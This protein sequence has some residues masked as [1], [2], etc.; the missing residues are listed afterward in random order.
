[1]RGRGVDHPRIGVVD[2]RDGF[3][4]GVVRQAEDRHVGRVQRV[5]PGVGGLTSRVIEAD[6]IDIRPV[7]QPVEDLEA[8]RA[9]LAVDEDRG[10]HKS[11]SLVAE[12]VS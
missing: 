12:R 5:A 7:F 10:A 6:Q 1:M 2:Q 4:R 9:G 8:G 11:H 3:A